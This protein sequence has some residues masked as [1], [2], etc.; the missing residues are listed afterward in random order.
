RGAARR[1]ASGADDHTAADAGGNRH[2]SAR[3]TADVD[4]RSYRGRPGQARGRRSRRFRAG[5]SPLGRLIL[6]VVMTQVLGIDIGGTGVN[7]APVDVT[8]GE[9]AAERFKLP[10]P[11]PPTPDAVA[12]VLKQLVSHF[13]WE[14][15]A[16]I[17]FPGVVTS[18]TIHTAPN[19]DPAWI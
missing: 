3:R 2:R 14:G 12:G 15:A 17:T 18:G 1:R 8:A 9:L 5:T 4:V 6:G 13:K 16:G 10:T 7:A 11:H 19:M